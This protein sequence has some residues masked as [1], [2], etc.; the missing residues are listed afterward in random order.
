GIY[1]R[2]RGAHVL[3][4]HC[5]EGEAASSYSSLVEAIRE[6]VATRPDDALKAEMGDGA[7]DL[8]KLVPEI[9]KRIPDLPPSPP[10]DPNGEQM[11]LFESVTSFLRN[12]SKANPIMLLLEDLHWADQASLQL[13]RHLARRFKGNRLIAVGTYRDVEV[14]RN[15]PLSTMLAE[16]R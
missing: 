5:Y 8:A 11:R 7:S 14:D 16:L 1:A 9:R 15:H 4:G 6:Y 10:A 13:L 3:V 12:A 2:Q